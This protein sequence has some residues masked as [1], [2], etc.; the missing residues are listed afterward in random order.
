M[1]L[2]AWLLLSHNST[3]PAWALTFPVTIAC[4]K[5][6][7][8][9]NMA[10]RPFLISFTFS[11]AKVSGSSARPRGCVDEG[12]EGGRFDERLMTMRCWVE[13]SASGL[14]CKQGLPS[15]QSSASGGRVCSANE[16]GDTPC[17]N[18]ARSCT[19]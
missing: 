1:L 13:Y 5:K 4:T 7:K 19:C 2:T 17:H 8:H 9:A 11:S 6:P 12:G 10:R 15:A 3:P 16:Q 18:A 14:V